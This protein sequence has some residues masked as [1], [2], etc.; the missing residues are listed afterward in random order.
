VFAR[1]ES[2]IQ[3]YFLTLK[4][5]FQS[6]MN[7]RIILQIASLALVSSAI[8]AQQAPAPDP[9]ATPAPTTQSTP[10]AEPAQPMTKKEL[11]AQR[12]QQKKEEKAAKANAKAAKTAAKAKEAQDKAVQAQEKAA[13][14]TPAPTPQNE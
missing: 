7:K 2:L 1:S 4:E 10:G 5:E 14:A 3:V 12:D 11:K 13:P 8:Y 6:K 9:Q